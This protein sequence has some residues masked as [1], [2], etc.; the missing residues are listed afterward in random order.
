VHPAVRRRASRIDADVLS[1][2]PLSGAATAPFPPLSGTAASFLATPC[3]ALFEPVE[4]TPL[5]WLELDDLPII[6]VG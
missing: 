2:S 1:L 6:R 3:Q 4:A 5:A